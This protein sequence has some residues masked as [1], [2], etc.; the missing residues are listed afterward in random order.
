MLESQQRHAR[1]AGHDESLGASWR[2]VDLSSTSA[3]SGGMIDSRA[4]R[5]C[6]R[7]EH[8]AALAT[9]QPHCPGWR[10]AGAQL[11][12]AWHAHGVGAVVTKNCEPFVL[13]PAL[14]ML[15][16]PAPV[17]FSS[18]VISSSNLPPCKPTQRAPCG[19]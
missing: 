14:A 7:N 6:P 8:T 3:N 15:S 17:C 12:H 4:G 19:T 18:R 10:T 5:Q 13:G 9:T 11:A 2:Q 16:T 1:M